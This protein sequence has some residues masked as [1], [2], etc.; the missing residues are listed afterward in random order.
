M[1]NTHS[2]NGMS[3]VG[4]NVLRDGVFG[5]QPNYNHMMGG[6]GPSNSA[7]ELKGPQLNEDALP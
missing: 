3:I 4:Q 6:M 2:N 1:P 5:A 7:E